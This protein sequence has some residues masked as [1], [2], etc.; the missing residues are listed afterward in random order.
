MLQCEAQSGG[1]EG[2]PGG[3][4]LVK[5]PLKQIVDKP[6]KNPAPAGPSG[7]MDF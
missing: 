4:L 5:A 6:E 3:G 1:A 2:F 7:G